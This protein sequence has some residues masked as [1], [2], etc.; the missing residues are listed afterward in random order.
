[1]IVSISSL[2]YSEPPEWRWVPF[3]VECLQ[4]NDQYLV[5]VHNLK[6]GI[7][8]AFA[9]HSFFIPLT[10]AINGLLSSCKV[11]PR[12]ILDPQ[13]A[14]V[15]LTLFNT[16]RG[17]LFMLPLTIVSMIQGF[18]SAKRLSTYLAQEELDTDSVNIPN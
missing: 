14:F 9:Q 1:M 5:Q 4:E 16:M 17:P 11:D 6:L 7:N 15:S 13:T 10:I 18:V 12:N 2:T 8:S 3:E